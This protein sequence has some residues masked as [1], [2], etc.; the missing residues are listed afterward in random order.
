MHLSY[1]VYGFGSLF[2][3]SALD[4]FLFG[5]GGHALMIIGVL[6]AI[7]FVADRLSGPLF[8]GIQLEDIHKSEK[9]L[10]ETV[11]LY[12]KSNLETQADNRV[13]SAI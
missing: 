10:E 1:Y 4:H 8:V 3:F 7:F 2:S 6:D 5:V 12:S 11:T 13:S 9:V